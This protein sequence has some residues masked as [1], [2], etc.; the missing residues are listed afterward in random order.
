MKELHHTDSLDG[1]LSP[2]AIA[3]VPDAEDRRTAP[4]TGLGGLYRA[5]A[6]IA[7]LMRVVM[8]V[9]MISLGLLMAAQVFMR[10]VVSLPFLGIEEMAPMLA[11]WV[12]FV[13]MA[14]STR[15]REHIEGGLL[16]LIVKNEKVL[17][18]V[19][20][21]GSIICLIAMVIFLKFAWDFA[22]FNISLNRKSSYMRLPKYLWDLSMVFGFGMMCLYYLLQAFLE[23]RALLSK[24]KVA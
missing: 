23:A 10:Y 13:G 9:A 8:F 19:R 4:Y 24:S 1:I 14:Y 21:F 18:A 17:L 20:L 22:S 3:P 2:P 5:E 6:G 11:V 16:S 12:Y 15:N 7:W